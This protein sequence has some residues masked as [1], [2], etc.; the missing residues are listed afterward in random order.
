[1]SRLIIEKEIFRK[2]YK[3]KRGKIFFSD[4]FYQIGKLESVNKALFRL[5]QKGVLIRIAQGIYL[6]P[7][8]D[9][10]LGLL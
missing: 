6:Y 5:E 8:I 7:K 4:D 9:K 10:E 3:S 1:M 2:I